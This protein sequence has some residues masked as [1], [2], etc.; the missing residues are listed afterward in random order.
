MSSMGLAN[1]LARSILILCLLFSVQSLTMS[2]VN[3]SSNSLETRILMES[4]EFKILENFTDEPSI[5]AFELSIIIEIITPTNATESL[6]YNNRCENDQI[7]TVQY[8]GS[9][10]YYYDPTVDE[11][12]LCVLTG[13]QDDIRVGV[14]SIDASLWM[15][16]LTLGPNRPADGD[17]SIKYHI[18]ASVEHTTSFT[19]LDG[20]LVDIQGPNWSV[21]YSNQAIVDNSEVA[22]SDSTNTTQGQPM[23]TSY[24]YS[25]PNRTQISVEF[26]VVILSFGLLVAIRAIKRDR[27]N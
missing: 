26:T 23:V 7:V 10:Q 20:N 2:S 3:A 25:D 13:W 6:V 17:Y 4:Q 15:Y 22:T 8:N 1:L 27:K 18:G 21:N 9:S 5:Q 11:L 24:G 12:I 19:Y 14:T 16:G